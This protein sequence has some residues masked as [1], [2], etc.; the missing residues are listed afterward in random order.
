MRS[1]AGLPGWSGTGR[2]GNNWTGV[3]GRSLCGSGATRPLSAG[4]LRQLPTPP[5]L[6]FSVPSPSLEKGGE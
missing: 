1:P 3:Q 4:K 5:T 6:D 2:D